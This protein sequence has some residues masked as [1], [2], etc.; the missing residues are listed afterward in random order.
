MC[1][2]TSRR[3]LIFLWYIQ[4]FTCSTLS[5]EYIC[6]AFKNVMYYAIH[7]GLIYWVHLCSMHCTS[8]PRVRIQC[9]SSVLL[10][11]ALGLG[12]ECHHCHGAYSQCVSQCVLAQSNTASFQSRCT[13]SIKL[14]QK[15][16]TTLIRS[17]ILGK[18]R[19]NRNGATPAGATRRSKAHAQT[20]ASK[21][22]LCWLY[23]T[24][25]R[26]QFFTCHTHLLVRQLSFKDKEVER[27]KD[28]PD[29][30]KLASSSGRFL[31]KWSRTGFSF[32]HQIF[33]RHL[34]CPALFQCWSHRP[35]GV[36]SLWGLNGR[37]EKDRYK[38]KRLHAVQFVILQTWG[39]CREAAWSNILQFFA[40]TTA[41]VTLC[42]VMDMQWC[43]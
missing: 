20:L 4:Y 26:V 30:L 25:G 21:H 1:R 32:L 6:L 39:F 18:A 13:V 29:S 10:F 5:G 22:R 7:H 40:I 34:L 37:K 17:N 23:P 16:P 11:P 35:R 2:V 28:D 38:H 41:Q 27:Q 33:S 24:A 14:S 42:H 12:S 15:Q 3:R 43:D 9:Q 8:L 31:W 36:N 19:N